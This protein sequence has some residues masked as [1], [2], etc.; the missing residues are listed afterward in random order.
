L[1]FGACASAQEITLAILYRRVIKS[2]R[3]NNVSRSTQQ[4]ST[5]A[6]PAKQAM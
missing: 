5:E 6:M 2:A 3:S 4:D 1:R